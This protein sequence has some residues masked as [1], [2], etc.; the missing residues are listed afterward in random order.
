MPASFLA[1]AYKQEQDAEK[2]AAF[3]DEYLSEES[4]SGPILQEEISSFFPIIAT[5][6]AQ[7]SMETT[8]GDHVE[9]LKCLAT[10]LDKAGKNTIEGA[11]SG[12]LGESA[13]GMTG[14]AQ[15]VTTLAHDDAFSAAAGV[16]GAH[17]FT[18]RMLARKG[19]KAK[20][21]CEHYIDKRLSDLLLDVF[22]FDH[23]ELQGSIVET[24]CIMHSLYASESDTPLHL[25]EEGEVWAL[26]P[27]PRLLV[28]HP[29]HLLFCSLLVGRLN[30]SN[31]CTEELA[32][33]LLSLLSSEEGWGCFYSNDLA[34]AMDVLVRIVIDISDD[35]DTLMPSDEK[36]R[37]GA[38]TTYSNKKSRRRHQTLLLACTTIVQKGEKEIWQRYASD[39]LHFLGDAEKDEKW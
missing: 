4:L 32:L 25:A 24:V 26:S 37:T 29:Q 7:T 20:A 18:L 36:R 35:I 38:N 31:D 12:P 39:L 11:L 23:E 15:L 22:E 10:A 27:L 3:V 34:V 14:T 16:L 33:F 19:V 2:A 9:R 6:L 8:A 13:M 30:E 1:D 17:N 5:D 28:A 21:V